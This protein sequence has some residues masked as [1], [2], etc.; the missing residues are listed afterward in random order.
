[1]S[2]A[3]TA[4]IDQALHAFP[5]IGEFEALKVDPARFDHEAHIFVAWSYLQ[6][7]ELL[8]AIDRYRSTL[9]RLTAALGVPGKYN[10]TITWFFMIVVQ[11][12]IRE[13]PNG[14]WKDFR[15]QNG[16]LFEQNAAFLK[17]HYSAELL[18]SD[19]ARFNFVL[20]DRQ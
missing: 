10:E 12:R 11:D 5:T 15:Q 18:N 4:V 2:M 3:K 19:R 6:K 16:D 8:H 7:L 17:A 13:S 20:P 1:M 9:R 14:D